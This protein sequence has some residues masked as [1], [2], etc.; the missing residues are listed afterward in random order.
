[1]KFIKKYLVLTALVLVCLFLT[2]DTGPALSLEGRLSIEYAQGFDVE[3]H[4]GYIILTVYEPW[5]GATETIRYV[6]LERGKTPPD[7]F[8]EENI[9]ETPL[10]SCVSTTTVNLVFMKELGVLATLIGQGGKRYVYD[11]SP[12]VEDLP[13][14]GTG[15]DLDLE[16]LLELSPE[17][18]FAYS[19]SSSE[20]DVLYQLQRMG[21]KV[22]LMSEYLENSPL[23]RAEWVKFLS[24]FFDRTSEAEKIFHRVSQR[25]DE[26]ADMGRS[27]DKKPVIFSNM[28]YNGVWYVPGGGNWVAQLFRDA[29][30]EYPWSGDPSEGSLALDL[31]TVLMNAS[32]ADVWLNPGGCETLEDLKDVDDR[33]ALFRSFRTGEIYNH[34]KR[35]DS[36]GGNDYHQR[37]VLHPE[38]ILEDLLAILHPQLFPGH[39][40]MYYKKLD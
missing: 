22:V 32:N 39:R 1:M 31:E 34:S 28:A 10:Q 14:I 8:R 11:P 24:F 29:G 17:V 23:G 25:Y 19:Y 26:L 6:L 38:E 40:L 5:P 37:G 13:E 36:R 15:A 12:S 7:G 20:R 30:G 4:E 35:V 27:M 21:L 33:Y 18:I 16:K 2:L 9:I 3:Y